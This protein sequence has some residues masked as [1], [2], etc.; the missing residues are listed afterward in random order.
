[1]H[2]RIPLVP[3]YMTSAIKF[4]ENRVDLFQNKSLE[5]I[6]THSLS[7][8]LE[9]NSKRTGPQMETTRARCQVMCRS[10]T[11][12]PRP[13]VRARSR[14]ISGGRLGAFRQE[15]KE[16][17]NAAAFVYQGTGYSARNTAQFQLPGSR[18]QSDSHA[19][20][21]GTRTARGQKA[22]FQ[23]KKKK[24]QNTT[25]HLYLDFTA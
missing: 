11:L 6:P 23:G 3:P 19:R 13:H 15:R 18:R 7:F 5:I 24:S 16:H 9:K 20:S 17:V 8:H 1:M 4:K 25:L 21:S 2:A 14:S 12:P 10:F 22:F